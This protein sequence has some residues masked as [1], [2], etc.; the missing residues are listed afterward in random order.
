MP[1]ANYFFSTVFLENGIRYK[2][3]PH[4]A[5]PATELMLFVFNSIFNFC[6]ILF[7]FNHF[8]H[9]IIFVIT[10]KGLFS[11]GTFYNA[12]SKC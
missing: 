3:N 2:E 12:L 11:D 9:F 6:E 8:N 5:A 10:Q 7:C 1:S 4:T